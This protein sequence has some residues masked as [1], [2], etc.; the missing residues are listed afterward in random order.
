M[1]SDSK[2]KDDKQKKKHSDSVFVDG[3][4]PEPTWVCG[5]SRNSNENYW[6]G[7]L[8]Y[9]AFVLCVGSFILCCFILFI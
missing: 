9:N 7:L 8:D 3:D 6:M 2:K 1:E 4:V 5:I